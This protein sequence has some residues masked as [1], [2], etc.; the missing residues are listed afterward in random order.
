MSTTGEDDR[1]ERNYTKGRRAAA[2][3]MLRHVLRDLDTEDADKAR[4]VLRLEETRA[5][6]R[7]LC[8]RLGCNDW[9]DDLSL[10]DVVDKHLGRR[11]DELLPEEYRR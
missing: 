3:G 4:L 7:R 9:E 6:L 1:D 5:Q 2:T 8:E 10:A 11:L